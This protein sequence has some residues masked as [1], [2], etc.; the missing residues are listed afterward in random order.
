MKFLFWWIGMSYGI[1]LWSQTDI[2]K[3]EQHVQ[4]NEQTY[5]VRHLDEYWLEYDFNQ[6]GNI[7]IATFFQPVDTNGKPLK[8]LPRH[9]VIATL[10]EHGWILH[11]N[12]KIL[13]CL[14][15]GGTQGPPKL[16]LRRHGNSIEFGASGGSSWSWTHT[17]KVRFEYDICEVLETYDNYENPTQTIQYGTRTDY[18]RMRVEETFNGKVFDTKVN[19]S[20]QSK[21]IAANWTT[22]LLI[23]GYFHEEA[24]R[25]SRWQYVL[26]PKYVFHGDTAWTDR[27]DLS[28]K[29]ATLWTEKALYIGVEVRDERVIWTDS[30]KNIIRGDHA[31]L[32]LD[33]KLST[34]EGTRARHTPD[35][36]I[37]QVAFAPIWKDSVLTAVYL[38]RHAKMPTNMRGASKRTHKGY[39]LELCIPLTTIRALLPEDVVMQEFS[40]GLTLGYT[41]VVSDT[42]NPQSETQETLM[43]TS[44]LEW[45]NPLSLGKCRL[46]KKYKPT[47][48]GRCE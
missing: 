36:G 6:D 27:Q 29:T 46:Y 45:G 40:E 14:A 38:P 5:Q 43:G 10:A 33:L 19:A 15:C 18:R 7:D 16:I 42:D 28:Y 4:N 48:L 47:V 24:W 17:Q 20:I 26:D 35:D 41:L 32:W 37:I 44:T 30:P 1:G 2:K 11:V 3:L 23:D 22:P 31:E 39:N 21:L 8:Q 34:L 25:H 9:F 13:P 12:E